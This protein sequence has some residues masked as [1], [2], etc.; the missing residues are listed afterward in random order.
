MIMIMRSYGILPVMARCGSAICL[1]W[2]PGVTTEPK[3]TVGLHTRCSL[4][5][6]GHREHVGKGLAQF[7]YQRWHWFPGDRRCYISDRTDDHAWEIA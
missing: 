3:D 6:D 7:D 1:G 2:H 5:D 4:E